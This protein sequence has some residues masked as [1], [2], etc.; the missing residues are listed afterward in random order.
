M[1]TK[2]RITIAA[3]ALLLVATSG[4]S[5]FDEINVTYW[6]TDATYEH[7]TGARYQNCDYAYTTGTQT[8]YEIYNFIDYCYCHDCGH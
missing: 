1:R 7:P 4:Y 2:L 3:I 8:E 6:Y 5:Y